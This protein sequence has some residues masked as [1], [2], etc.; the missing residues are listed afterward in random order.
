M[1]DQYAGDLSDLLK[2]SLLRTIATED[3]VLGVGWYYNPEHD[4]RHQDGRHREY[5]DEPHWEIL[6]PELVKALRSFS[7]RSVAGLEKLPIWPRDAIFHSLPVPTRDRSVWA[8]GMGSA[9]RKADLIFLDPDNGVG[10]ASRRHAT[11]GEIRDMSQFGK[12]LI[13]IKFPRR[14]NFDAQIEEHHKL[15]LKEV[16]AIS[17]LTIRTCV[18]VE[19]RNRRGRVQRIPRIRWFTILNADD[20]LIARTRQFT[21]R[22]GKIESCR[23]DMVLACLNP[24]AHP[25]LPTWNPGAMSSLSRPEIYDN[26]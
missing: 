11:I 18:S 10:A 16:T 15:L 12:P 2:F 4:G 6:D 20:A 8:A 1:R 9:S 24:K 5:C 3:K 23:A 25:E 14:E 17:V 19:V 22:L 13:L 21:Q 7:E 26:E